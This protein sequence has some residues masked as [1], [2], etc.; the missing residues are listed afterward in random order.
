MEQWDKYWSKIKSNSFFN[1]QWDENKEIME[2]KYCKLFWCTHRKCK[3]TE[4]W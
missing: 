4:N 2:K 1:D 3:K